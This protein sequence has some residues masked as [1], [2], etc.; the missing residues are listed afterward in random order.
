M[1]ELRSRDVSRHFG[2]KAANQSGFGDMDYARA[3]IK[4]NRQPVMRKS[5]QMGLEARLAPLRDRIKAKVVASASG[6]NLEHGPHAKMRKTQALTLEACGGAEQADSPSASS[7][8]PWRLAQRQN[9]VDDLVNADTVMPRSA[10]KRRRVIGKTSV[11]VL[12]RRGIHLGSNA[13]T[14]ATERSGANCQAGEFQSIG[15]GKHVSSKRHRAAAA[16]MTDVVSAKRQ[17]R[18]QN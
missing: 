5:T 2:K 11:T 13:G 4:A 1:A 12:T 7:H 9:E 8:E 6:L 18:A 14:L 15:K 10:A 16:D 17:H 3:S